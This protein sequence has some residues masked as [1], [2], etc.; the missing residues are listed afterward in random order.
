MSEFIVN[1][2]DKEQGRFMQCLV[3]LYSMPESKDD[4]LWIETLIQ[5]YTQYKKIKILNVRAM[6]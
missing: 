4:L 3:G 5:G 6:K 2:L 1:F